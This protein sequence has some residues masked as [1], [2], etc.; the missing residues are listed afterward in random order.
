MVRIIDTQRSGSDLDEA[1]G[2]LSGPTLLHLAIL[3]ELGLHQIILRLDTDGR[4]GQRTQ[5][6]RYGTVDISLR[7]LQHG[8]DVTHHRL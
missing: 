5:L 8:L 6:Q 7:L 2:I 1:L 4:E 3:A